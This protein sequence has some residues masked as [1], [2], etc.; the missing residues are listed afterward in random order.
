MHDEIRSA[1]RRVSARRRADVEPVRRGDAPA[2][3]DGVA[4]SVGAPRT[5]VRV[6]ACVAVA[7]VRGLSELAAR[8]D[9]P[10]VVRVMEEFFATMTD[11]AVAHRAAIDTLLG[12]AIAL[13]Y[14]MPV[15]RRDDPLRAVRAAVAMQH[16]F[17]ALRNRWIARGDEGVAQLALAVGVAAGEVLIA[18]VRPGA[19][20]DY[21]AVGDPVNLAAELCATARGGETL[22]DEAAHAS[23][24]MRLEG[25]MRF[26][27]RT[28]GGRKGNARTAYRVVSQRGGLRVV[29]PRPVLDPVCGSAVDPRH[30]VR[31]YG[32]YFCSAA[33]ARR[34]AGDRAG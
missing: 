17:L 30:G 34:F 5:G 7:R 16:A 25:E 6:R 13:F 27:S 22:I 20:S 33:C 28:L 9:P 15:P 21:T 23:V 19:W 29:P 2:S 14:G 32:R 24:F 3:D 10:S 12:E 31:E 11:V 1:R 8:L 26:S 4:A 18:S